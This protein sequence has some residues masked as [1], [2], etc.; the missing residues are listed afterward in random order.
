MTRDPVT[1]VEVGLRD[2]LQ[3]LDRVVPTADKLRWLAAEHRAGVRR[4]EAASFVPPKLLPQMADAAEMVA[5]ARALP[6]IIV[7]TLAPNLRGAKAAL[8]AGSDVIVL[9]LSASEAHSRANIR[10][11]RAESVEELAR[12]CRARDEGNHATRIDAG[13]STAFGCTIQGAVPED[14]V[15]RLCEACLEAGADRVALADTVGYA[16]PAQVRRL[17]KRV[18][19]LAGDRLQG[20]HFHDTRGLGLANCLAVLDLGI[21]EFDASLGGLGGCP[22]APGASGNVATE[23]LVFMLEAMGFDTG[24]DLDAL[25]EAQRLLAA[26]LP[27]QPLH[28]RI[29]AAGLPKHFSPSTSSGSTIHA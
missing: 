19:E 10:K 9:P 12:V 4:F 23:D 8:A 13:I 26:I 7:H 3:I 28:G 24:I 15:V 27:G 1:I 11:T 16:D 2:G 29:A 25:I 5:G 21:R 17:Y 18:K 14:E 6:D 20:A 22:H